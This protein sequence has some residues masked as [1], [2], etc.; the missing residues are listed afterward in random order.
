[1]IELKYSLNFNYSTY[2]YW[3]NRCTKLRSIKNFH[4]M[5]NDQI[6]VSPHRDSYFNW[7]LTGKILGYLSI[8]LSIVIG[9]YFPPLC[10]KFQCKKFAIA[11]IVMSGEFLLSNS[12]F[13]LL[14][15]SVEV[16]A[17]SESLSLQWR[18][19]FHILVFHFLLY[20]PIDFSSC[21]K[22]L[23]MHISILQNVHFLKKAC[24][25]LHF[26]NIFVAISITTCILP[27]NSHCAN[28][29]QRDNSYFVVV[30][31]K[32]MENQLLSVCAVFI[33]RGMNMV[34]GKVF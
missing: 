13:F 18:I 21:E 34:R 31:L 25:V 27:Q 29:A 5:K 14:F 15:Y 2:W 24:E 1:M 33:N 4:K 3:L 32:H 7:K 23:C 19:F 17:F 16:T 26:C 12:S 20:F 10:W 28:S 22:F 9:V 6:I 11:V 8:L 30:V